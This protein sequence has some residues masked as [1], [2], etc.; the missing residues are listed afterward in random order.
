MRKY[1]SYGSPNRVNQD[2]MFIIGLSLPYLKSIKTKYNIYSCI[3]TLILGY[4]VD[5]I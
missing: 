4:L 5:M 2:N 1:D 3:T